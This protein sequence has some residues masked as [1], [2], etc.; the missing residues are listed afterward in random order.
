M[1]DAIGLE[2]VKQYLY[3]IRAGLA[4]KYR[5]DLVNS[6]MALA[7]TAVYYKILVLIY[8]SNRPT[9]QKRLMPW[10]LRRVEQYL[11]QIKASS[12]LN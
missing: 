11:Y 6:V 10:D 2:G 9:S 3:Q 12:T 5:L 8:K 7:K 4:L 1:T